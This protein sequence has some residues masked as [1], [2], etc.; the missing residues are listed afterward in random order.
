MKN[1]T[2]K[3]WILN[4][5]LFFIAFILVTSIWNYFDNEDSVSNVFTT[6]ELVKAIVVS[7]FVGFLM[8]VWIVHKPKDDTQ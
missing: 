1:F 2:L 8:A 6:R 5:V 4:S 3:K 7:I